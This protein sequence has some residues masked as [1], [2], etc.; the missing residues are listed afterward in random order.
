MQKY[1]LG[2][3]DFSVLRENG[4]VYVD[5]TELIYQLIQG[6]CYFLSHPRRFGKSL[7]LSTLKYLFE[8]RQDLFEGLWI[9]NKITWEASPV[10]HFSFIQSDFHSIGFETYLHNHIQEQAEIHA[11][12]LKAKGIS[13]KMRELIIALH[14]KHGK[15]V[16]VL[17]D[18]YDKPITE[19]LRKDQIA[20]AQENRELMRQFYSPLKDLDKYL[21]FIF[22]TGVSKF[23]KVSIFSDLNHLEDIT[24]GANY[25]KLLGYTE[26]EIEHYFHNSIQKVADY[27]ELTYEQ[28]FAK[29]RLWYNG[30][31]WNRGKDKVYNPTSVLKF[32]QN[33]EFENY[34]FETGTPTFLID[35]MS[36]NFHY[37]VEDIEAPRS[38]LMNFRLEAL[39]DIT[40]LFQTGYLT[41]KAQDDDICT[42]T[43]PNQ[44][45]RD[46]MLQYLLSEFSHINIVKPM[47]RDMF[48]ALGKRDF[49]QLMKLLNAMLGEIPYEIFDTKQEKYYHAII[50]LTF[51]LL[52]YYAQAEPSVS[53]GRIDAVV[54]TADG[55]FIFE[56]KVNGTIEEAMAQIHENKYYQR[57][58]A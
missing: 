19:F 10:L 27:Q 36:E 54:E 26:E 31:S 30:Y 39:D 14:K 53:E 12:S 52:G 44:E 29:M 28:C 4:C 56:F 25:A 15:G 22:I 40:L 13:E 55:I 7:L 32:L 3:Q 1:P 8:G 23:S 16:V 17:V 48:R 21:R 57:Y 58:L 18:E 35:M 41:I 50:F 42:L 46:S 38:L 37:N 47:V 6:K 24:T 49:K 11:I 34:W 20:T 33:K 5:K 51:R 45:V 43:Y 2:I 9:H